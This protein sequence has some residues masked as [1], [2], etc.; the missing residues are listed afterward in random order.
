MN[1]VYH[2]F[3]L[4]LAEGNLYVGSPRWGLPAGHFTEMCSEPSEDISVRKGIGAISPRYGLIPEKLRK[5]IWFCA[6][7]VPLL[8]S[9]DCGR[10]SALAFLGYL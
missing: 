6:L 4:V 8:S 3:P 7:N 9:G 2:S 5:A 10:K 1:C